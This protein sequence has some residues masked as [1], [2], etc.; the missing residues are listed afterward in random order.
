M[1]KKNTASN[2]P[3]GKSQG[4]PARERGKRSSRSVSKTAFTWVLP[5][6]LLALALLAAVLYNRTKEKTLVTYGQLGQTYT[7]WLGNQMFQV[8][9]TVG[10]ALDKGCRYDF[11]QGV[12]DKEIAKVF[13][14][15]ATL[16]P[17]DLDQAVTVT[18]RSLNF[19]R[20]E[21]P[22]GAS[23]VSM[24]GYLQSPLYFAH[25]RNKIL[26]AF[27]FKAGLLESSQSQF[28]EITSDG[29]VC[30]HVRRGDYTQLGHIYTQL[31][32]T[33]YEEALR[34]FEHARTVLVFS[35]DAQ[36]CQEEFGDLPYEFKYS[37]LPFEMDFAALSQC[38][39]I[40]IA[41]SSFSWW[42]AF[43]SRQRPE[44]VAPRPWY[45]PSGP[46]GYANT[47]DMY[48]SDWKIIDVQ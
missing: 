19:Q 24:D 34:T 10:I 4:R 32:R 36:W 25:H 28:P 37:T 9:S 8:A 17:Q 11:L 26:D 30:L 40:I 46:L 35:N 31:D 1:P 48:L 5:L 2:H 13:D 43:M 15:R 39:K 23:V 27:R 21:F 20:F 16:S 14:I 7:G 38:R 12:K 22:P 6:I 3:P 42:A 33:Y 45:V 47:A 41:N 29:T 18:E 44:V